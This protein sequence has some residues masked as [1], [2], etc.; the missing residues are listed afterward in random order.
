MDVQE[1]FEQRGQEADE[2]RRLRAGEVNYL[3]EVMSVHGR[4]AL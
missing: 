2:K 1:R 3:N 4:K